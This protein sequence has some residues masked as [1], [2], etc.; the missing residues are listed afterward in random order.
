[1]RQAVL[2]GGLRGRLWVGWSG[3]LFGRLFGWRLLRLFGLFR[4]RFLLGWCG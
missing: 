4:R 3:L 2:F 1:L